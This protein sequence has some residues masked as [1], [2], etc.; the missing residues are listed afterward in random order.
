[1]Q[2]TPVHLDIG[3]RTQMFAAREL[4]H[5]EPHTFV[6]TDNYVMKIPNLVFDQQSGPVR[7]L[8]TTLQQVN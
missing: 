3:P 2:I 6:L 5:P 7:L 1:M 4:S 8:L